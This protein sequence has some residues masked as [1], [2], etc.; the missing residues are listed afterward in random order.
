MARTR[1]Q[2]SRADHAEP[3]RGVC[4]CVYVQK[5]ACVCVFVCA[6]ACACVCT[7]ALLI[8]ALQGPMAGQIFSQCL[9]SGCCHTE[10]RVQRGC[11]GCLACICMHVCFRVDDSF[12]LGTHDSS[13]CPRLKHATLFTC[14]T[15]ARKLW[16]ASP[17]VLGHSVPAM[18]INRSTRSLRAHRAAARLLGEKYAVP[19]CSLAAAKGRTAARQ[20]VPWSR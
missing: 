13:P 7:R 20:L 3:Q 8:S 2:S 11:K 17:E 1:W 18:C 5:C 19:P 12:D 15:L 16:L 9:Q 14:G 6:C 10:H 4:M